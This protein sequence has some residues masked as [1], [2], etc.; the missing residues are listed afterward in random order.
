ML[1]IMVPVTMWTSFFRYS[2]TP[3]FF[4]ISLHYPHQSLSS[5]LDD[6]FLISG[7]KY[8]SPNEY[9]YQVYSY[10]SGPGTIF[11]PWCSNMMWLSLADSASR[12]LLLL[13]DDV[14][15]RNKVFCVN[16]TTEAEHIGPYG[17]F[18]N[19]RSTADKPH[20]SANLLTLGILL[21]ISLNS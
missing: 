10:K 16:A 14:V 12:Q 7:D 6:I 3:C 9:Q 11:N 19:A 5:Y 13:P 2:E 17:C 20:D 21:A 18:I 1:P 4:Q 15:M 8:I